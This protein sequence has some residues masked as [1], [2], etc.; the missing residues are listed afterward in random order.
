MSYDIAT[1]LPFALTL[2]GAGVF[3]GII[4]GLL[5][6]GGGIVIVPVL[7]H[8]FGQFGIDDS[9]R[10]Q[11]SVGTS[12]ATIVATA[13]SSSSAH[14]RRGTVDS[15]FLRSYGPFVVVG[16]FLGS[17]IASFV[18]GPT[19]TGIFA[20]VA[21]LVSLQLA[22]GSPKW[23]LG[24]SMPTGAGRVGIG[25]GIGTLSSLM[26]IGG[27]SLSV[28]IMTMYGTPVHRAVGTAAATGFIIGVPGTLGFII[29]GW[30]APGLPP[31]SLG[32][33]N[34]IGLVL[35]MPTSMLCAPLGA[36]LAHA[37]NT[38]VLKRIFAAF[39]AFT[40]VRMGYT[41]LF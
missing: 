12:L 27:G 23:T 3:A 29:G 37:M 41:L 2:L 11:A 22:F 25:L 10:M 28:P 36:R 33:V 20:T 18:K 8:L 15:G 13:W 34:L 31:G 35:I 14:Y 38:I 26:G 21:F 40:A 30:N 39:L 24:T 5:G 19:L 4:S 6:V 32:F 17:A 7:F 9:V 1:L 16:V